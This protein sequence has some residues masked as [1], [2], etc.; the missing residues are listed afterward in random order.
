LLNSRH[1][2]EQHRSSQTSPVV[3]SSTDSANDCN[4]STALFPDGFAIFDARA[5]ESVQMWS[6]FAFPPEQSAATPFARASVAEPN[7]LGYRHLLGFYSGLWG[8]SS[9]EERDRLN[10][11]ARSLDSALGDDEEHVASS[12]ARS[13]CST[14]TYGSRTATRSVSGSPTLR[15]DSPR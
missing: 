13:T 8:A 9:P 10:D 7:G 3:V 1:E 5:A 4:A 15:R 2:Q 12:S 6:Y 14:S 11:A